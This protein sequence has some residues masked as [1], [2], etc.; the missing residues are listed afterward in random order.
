MGSLL[1]L[2]TQTRPDISFATGVLARYMHAP[3]TALLNKAKN[4]LRYLVG[5]KDL[6]LQFKQGSSS[7]DMVG[8]GDAD[9]AG[10]LSMR[11]ST[12]GYVFLW[13]GAAI[14]WS[15]KRQSTVSTSTMEA[16]YVASNALV[17]EA[18]WLRKLRDAFVGAGSRGSTRLPMQLFTDSQSA[19]S[20]LTKPTITA[21]SK[22]IDICHHFARDRVLRGDVHFSYCRT[23]DMAADF[24]TKAL[25]TEK[26]KRC[27]ELIGM[28]PRK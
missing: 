13:G 6:G 24:L 5:T 20:Q 10:D 23:D 2:S 18:L 3:T 28:I 4:V 7:M 14:S 19:L 15:S 1:Y 11:K 26:F 16:E 12:T 22:H 9:Y 17:R 8:F 25:S 21:R 27:R